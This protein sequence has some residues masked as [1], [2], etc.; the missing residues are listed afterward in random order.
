MCGSEDILADRQTDT[1]T[2]LMQYLATDPAG[3]VNSL[4]LITDA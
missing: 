1:H 2:Y 3:E 4:G